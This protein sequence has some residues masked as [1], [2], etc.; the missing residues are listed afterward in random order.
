M[1]APPPVL[2][3]V[4]APAALI[5]ALLG[6]LP[7]ALAQTTSAAPDLLPPPPPPPPDAAPPPQSPG[8]LPP[9]GEPP[10]PP[11]GAV[12]STPAQVPLAPSNAGAPPRAAP[13]SP[14]SSNAQASRAAPASRA[15]EHAPY[16]PAWLEEE[17][18]EAEEEA[19]P[20]WRRNSRAQLAVGIVLTSV[21]PVV[22]LG[23]MIAAAGSPDDGPGIAAA[24]LGGLGTLIGI[25]LIVNG[26][27][28]IPVDS[29]VP[30]PELFIGPASATLRF[31]F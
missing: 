4:A 12:P 1:R 13:S 28:K 7:D 11:P 16:P 14:P 29:A 10:P 30:A 24:V 25:P 21:G 19:K 20:K 23:G 6:G 15:A 8:T 2:H 31:R 9:L 27:Q 26:A 5:F 3:A 22:M 18:R 17:R